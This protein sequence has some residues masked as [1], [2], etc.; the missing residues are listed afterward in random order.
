MLALSCEYRV[1]LNNFIIGLNEAQIGFSAPMWLID[2][3]RNTIG[4]RQAEF[5]L[6]A[7]TLFK[8]E[9]AL[10]IGLV[11]E[12][13]QSK[14]EAIEKA[15]KFL[16]KFAKIPPHARSMTKAA[17]RGAN[18]QVGAICIEQMATFMFS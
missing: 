16:N 10:K 5:A 12:V 17:L 1:M 3:M 13:A 14:E 18:I 15:E 11:D 2:G 7:G 8:T 6:T 4:S 9:E